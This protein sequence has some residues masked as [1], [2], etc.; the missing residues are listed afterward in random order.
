MSTDWFGD[1]D[2][3]DYIWRL[4]L[5]IEHFITADREAI[6]ADPDA[7][8]YFKRVRH[9]AFLDWDTLPRRFHGKA[10]A[11]ANR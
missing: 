7:A 5:H 3:V 8:D 2:W 10:F 1:T 6:C 11:E 9:E 4:A